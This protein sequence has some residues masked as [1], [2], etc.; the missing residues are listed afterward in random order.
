MANPFI[1]H[2]LGRL[3]LQAAPIPTL[4]RETYAQCNE[5]IIIESLLRARLRSSGRQL[6]SV[7]YL[8]IGG[9]H[10]VQTSSTYLFY[11]GW[12]AKGWLVEA[13]PSLAARL[14]AVR[15]RDQVIGVAVSDR[16]DPTLS[17]FVHE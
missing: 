11:R 4:L 8:E 14:R 13:D 17:F 3:D 5:D 10:P 15:P 2:Q 12:G 6:S 7:R 1:A 9:N 16:E